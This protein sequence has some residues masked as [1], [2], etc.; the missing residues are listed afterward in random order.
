M[1][2]NQLFKRNPDYI[3]RRI[4]DEYVLVPIHQNVANMECIY[5]L[6]EVGA[7]VWE[8]LETPA[9]LPS[10]VDSVMNEFD[11]DQA[12]LQEDLHTFLQEM[13]SCGAIMKVTD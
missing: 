7:L 3:F 1:Q 9:S 2:E 12:T 6:N 5:T 11:V 13:E 10:L 4:V 8:G